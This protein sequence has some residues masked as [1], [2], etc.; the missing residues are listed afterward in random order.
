MARVVSGTIFLLLLHTYTDPN[1]NRGR[2]CH[3]LN[4][5]WD[6]VLSDIF[7]KRGLFFNHCIGVQKNLLIFYYSAV[8]SKTDLRWNVFK[9]NI[10]R[11]C[12]PQVYV[13]LSSNSL[14]TH[15]RRNSS[16]QSDGGFGGGVLIFYVYFEFFWGW[17]FYQEFFWL[18]NLVTDFLEVF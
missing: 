15:P 4:F 16:F 10:M 6:Q 9:S 8:C 1:P 2:I 13:T 17:K 5:L 18:R 11:L 14:P 7:L 12:S 3:L